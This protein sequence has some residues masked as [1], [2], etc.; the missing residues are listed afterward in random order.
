MKQ[1]KLRFEFQVAKIE[2][3]FAQ[4]VLQEN[5]GLWLFLHDLR[6]PI[7]MLEGLTKLYAG[8]H[9][10]KLFTKLKDQF[11]ILEDKLG[12]I[13]YYAAFAKEFAANGEI[14]ATVKNFPETRAKQE[15]EILNGL[16]KDDNWLNRKR[17]N[18][19][20]KKLKTI[21]WL[22]E[23]TETVLFKNFYSNQI[24]TIQEF[25][26]ETNYVFDNV[27][28]DVHELRRKMRWLS[29]YPGALQGAVQLKE[30]EPAADHLNKYLTPE[31]VSSPFNRF[32]PAEHLSSVFFLE[33]NYFLALSWMIAE[34]G[35][36]KDA[37][38]KIKALKDSLQETSLLN[39]TDS[40]KEAYKLLGPDYPTMEKIL[41][42]AS[43]IC[44]QFFTEKNLEKLI[45]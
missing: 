30:T 20:R 5:P 22:D 34:L 37:G 35:K 44:K 4:A 39:D 1:G 11:K 25:V 9:N 19:I 42:R 27:E 12:V 45:K 17:L 26:A 28:E 14:P 24:K 38:L 21:D 36:I 31:I 33:K 41:S 16:L 8:L 40:L 7:F 6:T 32:P 3:L 43:E 29:I 10:K 2:L 13:D 18:K 15:I 23:K